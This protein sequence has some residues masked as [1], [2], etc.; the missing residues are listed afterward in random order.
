MLSRALSGVCRYYGS[1]SG[2]FDESFFL[3][4]SKST[5]AKFFLR[6]HDVIVF[7]TGNV[8]RVVLVDGVRTPFQ[9]S[10]TGFDKVTGHQLQTV[11]LRCEL[12]NTF[13]SSNNLL[14]LGPF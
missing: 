6:F 9:T 5:F 10:N 3:L 12:R 13:F 14:D 4:F 7:Q 2:R 11:A 8:K 1:G